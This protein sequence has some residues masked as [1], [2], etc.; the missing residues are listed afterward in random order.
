[1]NLIVQGPDVPTPVSDGK[2]LYI[3]RD[4][5]VVFALDV[6]TGQTVYGPERLPAGT[7]T[8]EAWHETLGTQ[9]MTVTVDGTTPATANATFKPAAGS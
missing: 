5:G 2:L 7:Y 6:K 1:M 8:V 4:T 9:T 3:V